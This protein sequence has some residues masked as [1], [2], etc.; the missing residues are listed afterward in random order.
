MRCITLIFVIILVSSCASVEAF[1]RGLTQKIRLI[2]ERAKLKKF[3][4]DVV[5][6]ESLRDQRKWKK[7]EKCSEKRLEKDLAAS[8]QQSLNAILNQSAK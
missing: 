7:A 8:H 4:K 1:S 2:E 3:E 6:C 5:E